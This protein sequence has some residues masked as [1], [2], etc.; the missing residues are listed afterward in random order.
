MSYND[1]KRQTQRRYVEFVEIYLDINDPSLESEFSQD[2]NSYG[3]PKTTDDIRAYTGTDFRV[4]RYCEQFIANLQ[5]FAV[6]SLSISNQTTPKLD[7]GKSIGLRASLSVTVE[8]FEDN[9]AYSLQGGYIAN[10]AVKGSHFSKLFARNYIKQKKVRVVRGYIDINHNFDFNDAEIETYIVDSY[11]PPKNKNVSFNL[12]DELQK[13]DIKGKKIPEQNNGVLAFDIDNAVTSIAFT[14]SVPDEYGANGA[15]GFI[16]INK[17]IMSYT[18]TSP[19]TMDVVRAQYG[20]EVKAQSAGS[21]IQICKAATDKNIIDWITDLITESNIDN[22]YIDTANWEAL[23]N[24][25]LSTFNLSRAIYKPTEIDKLLNELIVVG[26]LAVWVDVKEAKI[27][28]QATATFDSSVKDFTL[29]D[30]QQKTFSSKVDDKNH[31]TR[32]IVRWGNPSATDTEE[33]NYRSFGVKSVQELDQKLGYVSSGSDIKTD[34]LLGGDALAAGLANRIVQRFDTPPTLV[35]F[36]TDARNIG[37]LESG[38]TMGL[39]SV[40]TYE[41]PQYIE[42]S[43]SGNPLV[44]YAQCISIAQTNEKRFRVQGLSY[45]ANIPTNVDYYIN[46]SQFDYVLANDTG[47]N[48]IADFANNVAREYVVVISQ[49]V[50]IGQDLASFA[51]DQG[52]FPVGAKLKLIIAGEI[53]GSGGNGGAGGQALYINEPGA[54]DPVIVNGS[55]GGNGGDGCNFTTDVV[56]D[57]LTG[58]IA[59]GGGGESG[60]TSSAGTLPADNYAGRGGNG[61]AGWEVGAGGAAGTSEIDG[62]QVIVGIAGSDGFKGYAIG[63]AGQLGQDAINGGSAGLAIQS[64]GNNIDIIAGNNSEQIK[65]AIV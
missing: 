10:R 47:F 20:T 21:T 7:I 42:C 19:S 63:N 5:C 52:T 15:T 29:D 44:K 61:G 65:G 46:D 31:V 51:F 24:G 1:I 37:L 39:S 3:T 13:I 33:A 36:E 4:Y 56:I 49:G 60:N 53:I 23:K 34:W 11:Q 28:I 54:P 6:N 38:L 30:Y 22:S 64:N 57:N 48:S 27:K 17:E 25:A 55:P 12:V 58:L 16:A 18:V 32:Q 9:D 45:Q 26:G 40:F 2:L 14:P 35:Q 41:T 43:A 8:D 59:G 50:L 62:V